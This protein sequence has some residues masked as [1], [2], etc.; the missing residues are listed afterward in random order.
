MY[1]VSRHVVCLVVFSLIFNV[2]SGFSQQRRRVS[3]PAAE[4]K[5]A[6]TAPANK[7]ALPLKKVVLYSNGVGYFERQGAVAGN[8]NVTLQFT[9][10]EIDD[11]LKSLV[12]I[13]RDRG[14]VS[15]VSFDT[16]KPLNIALSEFAF[17]LN[18][19]SEGI[20]MARI[21]SSF[22]G[23]EVEVREGQN[24]FVGK[25]VGVE[26]RTQPAGDRQVEALWLTIIN[27][28]GEAR[29]FQLSQVSSVKLLD[30]T[31]R[32]DVGRYLNLVGTAHRKDDKTVVINASGEGTRQMMVSY[33]VA[34]PIWKTTY[35]AVIDEK[36]QPYLQG[37]AIVDNVG[38]EDWKDVDLSLV[39]GAPVSFIQNLKQPLYRNR[40]VIAMPQGY[41][42]MPQLHEADLRQRD[43][44]QAQSNFSITNS[45]RN[46]SVN[47][48]PKGGLNT[49][50]D[51]TDNKDNLIK[52]SNGFL[53]Y[54]KPKTDAIEE[55]T[56]SGNS[57]LAETG[58][59]GV[60][61][62]FADATTES[63]GELFQY[64]IAHPVTIL[65]NQSALIPI[66]QAKVE[67]EAVSIFNEQSR[68]L[69]P[70]NGLRLKNTTGLTLDGGPIT[71][72]QGDSYAGEALIDRF[73]PGETRFISYAIDTGIHVSTVGG[74]EPRTLSQIRVVNNVVQMSLTNVESKTYKIS[75]IS[76]LPKT[77]IIE[78]YHR[79]Q[80][81]LVKTAEPDS[82]TDRYY[83]FRVEL[84]PGESKDFVIKE[85][86]PVMESIEISNAPRE[87]LAYFLQQNYV[88]PELKTKLNEIIEQQSKAV[89]IQ[90][91]I[92][93]KESTISTIVGDQERLRENIKALGKSEDERKL[94]QRYIT[95]L[96]NTETSIEKLRSE[97]A[98]LQDAK[99]KVQEE[100]NRE[101]RSLATD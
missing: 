17:S 60:A 58:V 13:D 91:Q 88:T 73:K 24:T 23:A 21:L 97:I 29:G 25:I 74:S 22:K 101:M 55:I 30:P 43:G 69:F 75:N 37:W 7:T 72:I 3:A 77:L 94:L 51:G 39:S 84:K 99:T 81:K 8:T 85:E 20:G 16:A 33:T 18:D 15:S 66:V 45:G 70:L 27:N 67:G 53:S 31:L 100:I 62:A 61:V 82:I 1:R 44:S 49:T 50:L 63:I 79:P 2:I 54:T 86:M 6:S 95:K 64:H 76:N 96:E 65:K 12:I 92:S 57:F 89:D 35:R 56:V 38:G 36:G 80:F 5:S 98:A 14:R 47:G 48:I 4:T 90:A 87:R 41:A 52:S 11:V 28:S 78:H 59:G 9:P 26:K 93:T 83:R 19:G 32:E 10:E 71:V 46:S 34:A 68:Q 42:V 40:P